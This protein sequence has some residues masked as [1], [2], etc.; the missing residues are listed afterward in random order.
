MKHK[1]EVKLKDPRLRALRNNLREIIW[2]EWDRRACGIID[3]KSDVL[4]SKLPENEKLRLYE[5]LVKELEHIDLI[6]KSSVVMCG[7]CRHRDKDMIYNPSNNQWFCLDCYHEHS[8]D[9]LSASS[10]IY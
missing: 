10:F 7:W 5:E 6:I 2:L 9:I 8:E 1:R 4:N 3:A